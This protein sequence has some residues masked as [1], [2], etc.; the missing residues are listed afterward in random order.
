MVSSRFLI[1]SVSGLAALQHL[2]LPLE[3]GNVVDDGFVASSASPEIQSSFAQNLLLVQSIHLPLHLL[4]DKRIRSKPLPHR[5]R[6][7]R[8][9]LDPLR[10]GNAFLQGL[11]FKKYLVT[12]AFGPRLI[13]VG[14]RD[15]A[16]QCCNLLSQV[17]IGMTGNVQF[18]GEFSLVSVDLYRMDQFRNNCT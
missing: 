1:T 5:D 18:L 17:T 16:L 8:S 15:H 11:Q 4:P 2:D 10:P 12:G 3:P 9:V 13:L 6:G 7:R 14:L